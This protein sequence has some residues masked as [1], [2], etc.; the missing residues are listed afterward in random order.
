MTDE[1]LPSPQAPNNAASPWTGTGLESFAVANQSL[2]PSGGGLA[3]ALDPADIFRILNRWKLVIL[4]AAILGPLLALGL[5]LTL[6]P[7]FVSTAQIQINQED[8]VTIKGADAGRPVMINNTEFLATQMGLL[9]SRDLA[10]RVVDAQRLANNPEYATQGANAAVRHDQ[11]TQQLRGQVSIE[12]VRNS[13]LVDI[14]VTSPNASMS[15]LLANSYAEQFIASNL[16]REFQATAYQ[17]KFLED[18]I[19]STRTKLEDS[20]RQVVAYAANQGI[21]ELGSDEKGT[22]RQSLEVANL[23]TLNNALAQARSD[24]IAAEQRAM[25]SRGGQATTEA[26]S[27]PVLQELLKKRADA[28]AEYDSKLAIFLPD[29]PAMIALKEQIASLDKNIARARGSMTS[30]SNLDYQ[31]AIARERELQDRVDALKSKVLDLRS[32]SIQYTI[33]QRDV[34][35]NRAL[36]DALLQNYKE[37]GVTGGLGSNKVAIVDKALP[38]KGQVSPHVFTNVI[39]GL[40]LGLFVGLVGVFLLEFIDDTIKSPEDVRSKLHMS[41]LGVLP[42]SNDDESFLESLLDPKSDL[43]EAAHSLRTT[44]Q[45]T[46]AHGIPRTLLV[47]SSRPGEGKSS[48]ALSLAVSLAKLGRKVLIIDADIRKPSFYVGDISRND[49]LGLSNVLNG[50]QK[51]SGVARKSEIENLSVVP[52]GPSV[53]NPAALLSDSLFAALLDE[54]KRQY[55]YVI[56]DGPPVVGLADAPL[57]GSVVEGAI[58][59]VESAGPHRSAILAAASRLLASKTPLLGA[60]LN[61]FESQKL[62]YGSG[63]GYNYS[64]DYGGAARSTEQDPD[65][66]IVLVK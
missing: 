25:Q 39:L 5:S 53:P 65:R 20:E 28:Q 27:N 61:K 16:D 47:S 13:R 32:R 41:L 17:R 35:T 31:G 22:A 11:A 6:T 34:D 62:G 30:A 52:S 40:L 51:L 7:L 60:V 18:R 15:A 21:I 56:V 48:V 45:F 38:A 14:S 54:A 24:R 12:A 50:E 44:L 37:V 58:L 49:T 36:Y 9:N 42:A 4:A 19:A 64:Y 10:E 43:I 29:L 3:R 1:P 2:S 55:D 26:N 59:V 33:L 66:K 23:V 57:M 8:A 63:Y 46:T